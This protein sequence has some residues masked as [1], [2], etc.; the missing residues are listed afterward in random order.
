MVLLPK[1]GDSSWGIGLLEVIWKLLTSIIDGRLKA[2]ISFHDALHGF[3]PGWGTTTAIIKAKLFQ[4][5]AS[6]QQV[7]VFKILLDLKKAYDTLDRAHTL[8]ILEQYG[9]GALTLQLLRQFWDRQLGV[10]KQGGHFGVAFLATRG[11]TQGD[12]VSPTIFN[13][14]VDAI[15]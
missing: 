1:A 14:V 3:R 10:A 2:A 4:Q 11:V 13:I 8:E 6:I 9:V 7:P 15:V 12:I 5:L